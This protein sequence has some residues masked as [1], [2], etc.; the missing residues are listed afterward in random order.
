MPKAAATNTTPLSITRRVVEERIT[1]LIDLLDCLDGDPDLEPDLGS[2]D[3][4]EGEDPDLE[5]GADSEPSLGWQATHGY[6][7][8]Q[9]DQS[10]PGFYANVDAGRELEDEHDGREPHED[11]EPSLGW[12]SHDK[13]GCAAWLANNLG[14]PDLEQGV[15]AVRKQRPASKTGGKVVKGSELPTISVRD[16]VRVSV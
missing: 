15:G 16:C 10:S 5:D 9:T 6:I 14:A 12:T 4:R 13:Q 11:S 8:D 7:G 2:G 3:D 1:A